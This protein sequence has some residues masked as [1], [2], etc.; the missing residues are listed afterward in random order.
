M[1]NNQ[2]MTIRDALRQAQNEIIAQRF[3]PL[4]GANI[5]HAQQALNLIAAVAQWYEQ[6]EAERAKKDGT[7]SV[8][9][10]ASSPEREEGEMDAEQIERECEA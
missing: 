3:G 1:T 8:A 10:A 5:G 7:S 9:A 4:D 6:A 2:T